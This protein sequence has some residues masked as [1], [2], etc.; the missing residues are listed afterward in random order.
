MVT[1]SIQEE[2]AQAIAVLIFFYFILV[3]KANSVRGART[4]FEQQKFILFKYLISL[5]CGKRISYQNFI[6]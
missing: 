4:P 5:V 3:V 2:Q 1:I 6:I